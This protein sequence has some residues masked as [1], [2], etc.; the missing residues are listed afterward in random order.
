M[1]REAGVRGVPSRVWSIRRKA[2][3]VHFGVSYLG[4]AEWIDSVGIVVFGLD[5]MIGYCFFKV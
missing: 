1:R 4:P 2:Q 3:D 5:E